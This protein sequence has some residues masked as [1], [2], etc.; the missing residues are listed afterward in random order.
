MHGTTAGDRP[1]TLSIG[2]PV[3]NG[4]KYL[5]AAIESLLAQT[6]TDFELII[7]DNASTDE[8][9]DV[10][11]EYARRDPRV[12]IFREEV[13]TGAVRNHNKVIELSRG[14]YFKWAAHDDLYDPRFLEVCIAR[15][16][17]APEAVL[18]FSR[19]RFIDP[20]GRPLHEH[21][22]PLDFS[23]RDPGALFL[24]Y[25]LANHVMIE[26]YGV[27]RMDVLRR[28]S[29]LGNFIWSDM[30]L[31]GELALWGPFIEVPEVLFFRREHPGRAMVANKDA[32]AL[33]AWNDPRNAGK[34][35]L[36]TWRIIA[37]HMASLRRAP[38]SMGQRLRL[39][40]GVM[41]RA[42]WHRGQLAAELWNALRPARP[43][44]G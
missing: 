21:R 16:E 14:R 10:C 32:R 43:R 38:L 40:A 44:T 34:R 42:N 17:A 30:V 13:N 41:R 29:L 3:Y 19:A 26:D 12:R 36:P 5:G 28:T 1:V 9:W 24:Q 2:L 4:S 31:F 7:N 6:F 23:V 8:T 18:A 37:E 20:E 22:H 25:V 27:I 39:A 15:L 33:A 11:R 35:A